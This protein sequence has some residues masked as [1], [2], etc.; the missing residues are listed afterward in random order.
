MARQNTYLEALG[1]LDDFHIFYGKYQQTP[2]TCAACGAVDL[3][4][5]EKMTDVN[6]AVELLVDA[7]G[8]SFDDAILV[9]ADSDLVAPVKAVKRLFPGKRLILAFPP[10][11]ASKE[12]RKV[13]DAAF[14]IGRAKLAASQFPRAVKWKDGFI[15]KRPQD[16]A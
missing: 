2:R 7:Y 15:L 5:S 16:W 4:P 8:N 6:I 14:T 13:A 3:V 11:R 1:A 9:S 10:A 12:L